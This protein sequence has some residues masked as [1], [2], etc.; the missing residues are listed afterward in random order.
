MIP[1]TVKVV[2]DHHV[3][4]QSHMGVGDSIEHLPA[5][6]AGLD[7]TRQTKLAKLVTGGRLT[8]LNQTGKVTDAHLPRL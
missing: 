7:Q 3:Q 4:E 2:L 6:F 1:V 8:H 5:L